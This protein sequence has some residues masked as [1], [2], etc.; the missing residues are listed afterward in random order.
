[1]TKEKEGKIRINK[2]MHRKTKTRKLDIFQVNL[3]HAKLQLHFIERT[4]KFILNFLWKNETNN[5]G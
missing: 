4:G 5:R 2:Y 1:M 3:L